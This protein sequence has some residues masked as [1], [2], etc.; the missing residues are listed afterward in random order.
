VD[1]TNN[2][3]TWYKLKDGTW[4]AKLRH[5]ANEGDSVMLTNKKGEETQ[6][7]LVKKIAQFP[8]ASLW[9]CT[10]EQPEQIAEEEPF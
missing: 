8:D 7:W 2:P 1:M 9:S 4:G 5:A 3:N 6:V 10:S